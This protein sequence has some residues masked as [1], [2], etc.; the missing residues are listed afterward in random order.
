MAPRRPT[1][2]TRPA[3]TAQS[4]QCIGGCG[5]D[6]DPHAAGSWREVSGW[7]EARKAGGSHAIRDQRAT[8]RYLCRW[9]ME[10]RTKGLAGQGSLL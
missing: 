5:T 7:V 3:V 6:V 2:D 1:P 4:Y 10:D 8:G 9:C